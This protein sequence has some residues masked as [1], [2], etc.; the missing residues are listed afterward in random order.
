MQIQVTMKMKVLVIRLSSIGDIVLTSPVVRC[1]KQ[2]T[3]CTLHFLTKKCYNTLVANNPYI[4]KVILFDGDIKTT[5]SEL[6]AENYDFI[7][8]LHNNTRSHIIRRRLRKPGASFNKLDFKKFLITKFK[9]NLLPKV[10]VV[11]RYFGAVKKLGVEND[12][13]GLDY[14]IDEKEKMP[15]GLELSEHYFVFAIGGQHKTKIVPTDIIV[16]ICNSMRTN[17]IYIIGGKEDRVEGS[18]IILRCSN[19]FNLTDR[20]TINQS[21][22][23]IRNADRVFTGDT[24]MMHIA[25]AFKK[26][27]TSFWGNTIPEFGMYPY[28]PVDFKGKSEIVENKNLKCRPCSKLGYEHCPKG[29]FMCMRW[30]K[31]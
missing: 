9:I 4:D 6:K 11:D 5:V 8:D 26:D 24:G 20:L 16:Q 21:A 14:F 27:I 28:Y 31:S 19:V 10:H 13:R 3:D 23:V 17:K 22:Q 30:L 12:G 2:Q 18:K 7:V 1:L 25:A 15:T 29:H